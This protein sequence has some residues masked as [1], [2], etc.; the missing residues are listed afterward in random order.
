MVVVGAWNR[1]F[2]SWPDHMLPSTFSAPVPCDFKLEVCCKNHEA[3]RNCHKHTAS[4]KAWVTELKVMT[5][6]LRWKSDS[7][8]LKWDSNFICNCSGTRIAPAFLPYYAVN[9]IIL[10]PQYSFSSHFGFALQYNGIFYFLFCIAVDFSKVNQCWKDIT[11]KSVFLK[12]KRS[13]HC[14]SV[15]FSIGTGVG[16][17][18]H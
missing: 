11:A 7:S 1:W 9:M 17:G 6:F 14:E 13:Q 16:Y 10:T 15:G 5:V 8:H 4:V 18:N 2:F 12:Q 3:T